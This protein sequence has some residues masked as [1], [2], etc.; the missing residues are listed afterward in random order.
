[1]RRPKVQLRTYSG[2][3][4]TLVGETDVK[5][6]YGQQVASLPLI[7][8]KGKSPNLFD[9]N[10]MQNLKLK[11]E[12][13]FHLHTTGITSHEE[14]RIQHKELITK[15]QEVFKEKMGLLEGA[16]A[17]IAVRADTAPLVFKTRPVPYAYNELVE[18]E[19]RRLERD[20]IIEAVRFSDWAAPVLPV[21]KMDSSIRICGDFRLTINQAAPCEK[22]PLPKIN[23]VFASLIGG[24][25][26]TKLELSQAYQQVA[27]DETSQKYVVIN[28]HL[29]LFKYKRLP[30]GWPRVQPLFKG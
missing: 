24:Q 30:L 28:N 22:Y 26:F 21:L 1:M 10:W 4:L 3:S 23:D 20:E 12:D 9:R 13:I 7:I 29:G 8:V 16:T 14:G 18:Q 17:S 6:R 2:E 15:Y 19:L 27:L 25:L 11:W 5:V